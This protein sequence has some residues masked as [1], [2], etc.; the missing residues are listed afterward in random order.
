MTAAQGNKK[1]NCVHLHKRMNAGTHT[2][3]RAH[4]FPFGFRSWAQWQRRG[5]SESQMS[6]NWNKISKFK[7]PGGRQI[8][9]TFWGC[10]ESVYASF[11]S[12]WTLNLRFRS[13][14][15]DQ[16]R[17]AIC[18]GLRRLA[19]SERRGEMSLCGCVSAFAFTTSLAGE[20]MCWVLY[21][22]VLY[23]LHRNKTHIALWSRRQLHQL[24]TS[25][26]RVAT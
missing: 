14:R 21:L 7:F 26:S 3:Y 5:I 1:K 24:V 25:S 13:W 4:S 22:H 10:L 8:S 20:V 15:P 6:C 12:S 9:Q 23:I 11:C 17:Q 2:T 19:L 18:H 16:K